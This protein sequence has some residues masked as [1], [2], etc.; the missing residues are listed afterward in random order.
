MVREE[1]QGVQV[2]REEVREARVPEDQEAV[3]ISEVVPD[4]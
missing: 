3:R 4:L 2:A 1:V